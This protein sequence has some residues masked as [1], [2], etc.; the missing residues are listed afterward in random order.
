MKK[1]KKVKALLFG[2]ILTVAFCFVNSNVYAKTMTPD[3]IQGPAYVIGSHVF[4]REVNENTAYEGRLTTN[5][6]MLASQTIKSSDLDSMIIYY[7][8]ASG[9][10]IN[11]LTGSTIDAP[12]SFEINYT[13]LQLEEE[14]ST[15]SAPKTPIISLHNSPLNIDEET[16]M[17]YY[18]L[19]IYID[20]IDD[21]TNKVDGVELDLLDYNSRITHEEL[22][23][24]KDFKTI[25]TILDSYT[26]NDL[27]IGKQY[28]RDF[29]TFENKPNGY[30]TITARAYV[31]DGNGKRTYSDSV[32]VAINPDTT[33][34]TVEIVNDYSNSDYIAETENYYTYRLGIKK[35][36]AYV[37]KARPQKFAYIVYE[38]GE[39]SSGQVGIFGLDEKFTVS[40]AKESVKTYYAQIGYYD[41][42]GD[43]NHY[44]TQNSAENRIYFTIDTRTLTA[45]ILNA[46]Q[47]GISFTDLKNNGEYLRINS[48]FYEE[49]EEDTLD[50]QIE[51]TEIYRVYWISGT[52]SDPGQKPVYELVEGKFGFAHVFTPNGSA[53][54]TARVYA[55]NEEGE[56]VYSDFS[57]I[58]TVIRTPEIEVSEVTDGKVDVSIVNTADYSGLFE[59]NV[60][61]RNSTDGEVLLDSFT[62][63]DGQISIDV[64]EDMEIYVRAYDKDYESSGLDPV[65]VYSAKSNIVDV[66]IG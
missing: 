66:V 54:Y 8:T 21:T 28:H 37:F 15:V 12:E 56:K 60:Y 3:E 40:V 48:E 46:S 1:L 62:L 51:G 50:Y 52:S 61:T 58:V 39:S 29:I 4:T 2:F 35:P 9:M 16:D 64:S 22:T 18:Q 47:E 24:G 44:Y 5:F 6:I 49:Q 41:V 13:N 65:Y 63:S 11:G 36:E 30:Y 42:N 53:Y 43:F 25:T 33:L 27:V 14:N 31:E 59:F 45:P 17:M 38:V 57:D 55:T 20:D 10:W 32:Y 7:K 23:Y 34:P 26:G 19:D